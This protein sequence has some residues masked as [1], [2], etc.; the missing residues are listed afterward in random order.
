MR[1]GRLVWRFVFLLALTCAVR[2]DELVGKRVPPFPEG[3]S[4]GGGSCIALDTQDS[5]RQMVSVLMSAAGKE[6]GIY[7]SVLDGRD[8]SG[9]PFVIVTDVVPYPK[10]NKGYH[11]DWST[12]RYDG[13][14]DGAL[15]AVV[16]DSKQTWLRGAGWAYRVEKAS[17]KLSKLDSK[18]VDC[19]NTALEAD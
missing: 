5:C 14:E 2:A 11:L 18:H 13:V 1:V 9:K 6:M 4:Q 17:G 15:I 19:Y 8:E 3:M 16:K 7:A 12:C 10:V